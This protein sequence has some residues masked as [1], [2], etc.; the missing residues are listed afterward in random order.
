MLISSDK[1]HFV[2]IGA[3]HSYVMSTPQPLIAAIEGSFHRSVG[4][5]LRDFVLLPSGEISGELWLHIVRGSP[6][7]DR[8]AA[9]QAG[10]EP[11]VTSQGV[12]G[13]TYRARLKGVRASTNDLPVNQAPSSLNRTYRVTVWVKGGG[14]ETSIPLANPETVLGKAVLFPISATMLLLKCSGENACK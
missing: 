6:A 8:N 4:A 14:P 2:V 12:S 11:L 5:T 9:I 1:K 3:N 10:F 13:A 7:E